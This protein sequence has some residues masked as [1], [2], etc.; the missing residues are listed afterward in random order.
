MTEESKVP[1][2]T[3]PHVP[4]EMP[5]SS[6]SL[7]QKVAL[8]LGPLLGLLVLFLPAPAGLSV[9]S[10]RLVGLALW[11][12]LWWLT[13]AVPIPATALL[14][15]CWMPLT[16]IAS[17]KIVAKAYGHHLIFLFLGGFLLAFAMETW[18]LHRR[19]ALNIVRFVGT[20][21]NRL[22]GGF[23]LASGLMSMWITNTA[24]TIMMFAVAVSLLEYLK[25]HQD[26]TPE[27]HNFGVVLMLG[28]AYSAS[29]GGLGTLVGT[30]PNALFASFV[31]EHYKMKI[32]F[33]T[34]MKV[35]V[36]IVI[37][38][39][40]LTWWWL[41]RVFPTKNLSLSGVD[42]VLDQ[43]LESMGPMSREEK[44]VLAVFLL[45]AFCWMLRPWIKKWTGIPLTDTNIAIGGA[46]LLFAFPRSLKEGRFVLDWQVSRKMPWGILLLFGGGLALASGFKQTGLARAIG[47]SVSGLSGVSIWWV[48]L[49]VTVMVVFL[50]EL[51]SN[52]ATTATFLP[53]MAAVAIG[54][55]Q[56]PLL[57]LIPVCISASMAFM[58]PVATPPNAIVFAYED[59]KLK[60]MVKAGFGLNVI[61]ITVV[62]VVVYLLVP[63]LFGLQLR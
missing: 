44:V 61:A 18:G 17:Q 43:E 11:M 59:L 14:P 30:V 62:F 47:Q 39:L 37:V 51:T 23:M 58:M 45:T 21:P 54:M 40:P 48:V 38:M 29:I 34:W 35:G 10:W 22:L 56:P 49:L 63:A 60:D 3:I 7:L 53:V 27:L 6:Y 15:L 12:A 41:S 8:F 52:T 32:T 36:P 24:T 57:L 19:I 26:A 13:E 25:S 42:E 50:T 9:S 4:E 1:D 28:I 20:S 46:L 31:E 16:G 2:T 55:K 33:D 5:V